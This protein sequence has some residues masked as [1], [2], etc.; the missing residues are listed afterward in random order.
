MSL[1][2]P[3]T[4]LVTGAT[5]FLGAH[6]CEALAARGVAI[7]GLVRRAEAR[8]PAGVLPALAAG[9]DDVEALRHALRGVDGVVH[10][11][12]RV[13]VPSD[14]DEERAFHAVNVDGTRVLLE[15]SIAAGARAFVLAS[16]V[17]AVGER[18]EAPWD[19]T[20]P[21]T[22]LDAYGRTKL[23]AETIVR[24]L[25]RR[26]G[27]HAPIL[28]LPLVYGP[29][30]KGNAMRLFRLVD[31]GWPLPLGAV[32]NR[33]SLLYTG[34]LVAAMLATLESPSGGDTF[35]VTDTEAPSTPEL[36]TAI[37]HALGRPTRLLPVPTALLRATGRAGDL[38]AHA[39]PFPLTTEAVDRLATSLVVDGS[40]LTRATGYRPP[41]SMMEGLR[42][43]AEWYHA[44]RGDG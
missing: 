32:R 16:S 28:R 37:A 44:R 6:V 17:K 36:V 42:L 23:E 38:F 41:Y 18:S 14:G 9:L 3:R 26:H 13:H 5:G 2:L 25:A 40:R 7:R 31:R 20:T 21:P 12:A 29:G 34:N 27:I 22:P 10:L 43:T 24:S 11:A 33:R 15:E 39:I 19:E 1:E 4:V 35:F 30:M 8:L